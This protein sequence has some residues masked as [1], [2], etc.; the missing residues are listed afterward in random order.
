MGDPITKQ[1]LLGDPITKKWFSVAGA[2]I[3][4][5][6]ET[7]RMTSPVGAARFSAETGAP[8]I[9]AQVAATKE[10][11]RTV[12]PILQLAKNSSETSGT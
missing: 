2:G 1:W 9:R 6:P 5:P 3:M 10:A 7:G 4:R 8:S 11:R 12:T